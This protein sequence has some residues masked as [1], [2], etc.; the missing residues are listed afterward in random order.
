MTVGFPN[1]FNYHEF[2]DENY[3]KSLT[4]IIV[5]LSDY[6]M[7]DEAQALVCQ[8]LVRYRKNIDAIKQVESELPNMLA[9][10]YF[11]FKDILSV[12]KA[13]PSGVVADD[14]VNLSETFQ[15]IGKDG[16]LSK[17]P[18]TWQGY[19]YQALRTIPTLTDKNGDRIVDLG[20][21]TD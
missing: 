20:E 18:K 17:P 13:E 11:Q 4:E 3:E 1:N 15:K 14:S 6:E 5:A 19:L 21:I 16:K 12:L 2:R 7:S 9:E 10:I 8:S